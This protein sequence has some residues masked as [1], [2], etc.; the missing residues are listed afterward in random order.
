MGFA[1]GRNGQGQNRT[2][3][4]RI[5]SS[6]PYP[7]HRRV[8][9]RTSATAASS[10]WRSRREF[11]PFPERLTQPLTQRAGHAGQR[12]AR[13]CAAAASRVAA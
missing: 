10:A 4:T 11:P 7:H 6:A 5:F 3:D 12:D 13:C 2:A 8:G 1:G 9:A